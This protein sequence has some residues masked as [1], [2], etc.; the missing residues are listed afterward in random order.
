MRAIWDWL[1]APFC[2]AE[3]RDS[4]VWIYEENTVTGERRAIW[5]PGCYQP[6]HHAWLRAGNGAYINGPRGF[7][8]LGR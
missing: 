6:L 3:R 7:E 4:G 5:R 1:R 8:R 2:W